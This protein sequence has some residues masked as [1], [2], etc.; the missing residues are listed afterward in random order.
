MFGVL[1]FF[2]IMDI[3]LCIRTD[4]PTEI[5][6]WTKVKDR[7]LQD[8]WESALTPQLEVGKNVRLLSGILLAMLR[9]AAL[10]STSFSHA[11]VVKSPT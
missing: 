5:K 7:R 9:K 4:I 10:T 8:K 2:L 1:H 6:N 11:D 3:Q